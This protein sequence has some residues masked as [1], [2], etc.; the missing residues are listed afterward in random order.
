MRVNGALILAVAT[1]LAAALGGCAGSRAVQDSPSSAVAAAST[2]PRGSLLP[3]GAATSRD[4]PAPMRWG[5]PLLERPQFQPPDVSGV[6]LSGAENPMPGRYRSFEAHEVQCAAASVCPLGNALAS[7][8]QKIAASPERG[9]AGCRSAQIRSQMLAYRAAEERNKAAGQ[10]LELFYQ[11][12]EA[13]AMRDLVG[14]SKAKTA[15]MLADVERLQQQG[16]RVEKGLADLRRQWPEILERHS[17]VQVATEQTNS[18]LRQL[19]GLC[20]DDPV[21]IWP[22]ADWKVIPDVPDEQTAICQGMQHRADI[23]MLTMLAQSVDDDTLEASGAGLAVLLGVPLPPVVAHGAHPCKKCCEA[24]ARREQFNKLLAGRQQAAAE[25]IRLAVRVANLR[26]EQIAIAKM[27]VDRCQEEVAA[28]RLRRQRPQSTVTS[29]DVGA[30]ELQCIERRSDLI[31]R[32]VAWRIAQAKLKEAQGLL[33]F[34]CG[35]GCEQ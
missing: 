8:S 33:A 26:L 5:M 2:T 35:V 15:A 9:K 3:H 31:H 21:R 28:L 29:L 17:Q 14:Q 4:A 30:A 12:S 23:G 19:L 11:L 22:A 27:K 7:E 20:P 18:H 6:S 34:E 1:A 24:A 32:V 25:D 16:I 13:E 10:A